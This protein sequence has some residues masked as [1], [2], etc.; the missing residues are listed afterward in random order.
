[1]TTA[2]ARHHDGVKSGITRVF[3]GA[4]CV[5]AGSWNDAEPR[6]V[7]P[8]G[9][10]ASVY[11]RGID[12]PRNLDVRPDGTL[13]LDGGRD[14]FEIAPATADQPLT[15]MR[16]AAELDT[17]GRRDGAGVAMIA[18]RFVKLRWNAD[19]GELAYSL[20]PDTG[21]RIPIARRTLDLA[22]RFAQARKTD[23]AMAPDGTLYVADTRAG[24]VWRV[25]PARL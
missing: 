12:A 10:T 13:T 23:V 15:V 20:R 6:L 4:L 22:R 14:R 18:P 5:L 8:P 3:V 9:F 17:L 24:A 2:T 25:R 11:A 19:S 7:V 21:A 1:V 16:V